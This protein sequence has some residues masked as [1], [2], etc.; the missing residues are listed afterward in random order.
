MGYGTTV[1]WAAQSDED[2]LR[3]WADVEVWERDGAL[4][5]DAFLRSVARVVFRGGDVTVLALVETVRL[6]AMEMARRWIATLPAGSPG[7]A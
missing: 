6:V 7:G 1:D 2:L 5:D 4:P 3:A